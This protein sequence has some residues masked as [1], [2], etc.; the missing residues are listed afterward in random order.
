M[1]SFV[2]ANYLTR[3][4]LELKSYVCSRCLNCHENQSGTIFE[5][6]ASNL[7]SD[8]D[9]IEFE[10]YFEVDLTRQYE[11]YCCEI[12]LFTNSILRLL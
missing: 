2:H 9:E 12:I 6:P 8:T 7:L 11:R 4:C 5:C 10:V 3:N 1:I